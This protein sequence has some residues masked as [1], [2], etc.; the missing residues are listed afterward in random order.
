MP[1]ETNLPDP[2]DGFLE[3]KEVVRAMLA[4]TPNLAMLVNQEGMI[5]GANHAMADSLSVS[6]DRLTG[7]RLH[8][9]FLPEV[10]ERR[11]PFLI[12]ALACGETVEFEDVR[13]HRVFVTRIVPIRD[14]TGACSHAFV[15]SEDVTHERDTE[16]TLR[17]N[18]NR[19]QTLIESLPQGVFYKDRSLTYVMCN[20]RYARDLCRSREEI[21]GTSDFDLF[22]P[23]VA[24]S[25]RV[26]DRHVLET[27]EEVALEGRSES[28]S[29]HPGRYQQFVKSPVRDPSGQVVGILGIYW[30]ITERKRAE[31]QQERFNEMQK[32]MVTLVA[33][34]LKTPLTAIAG[35][36]DLLAGGTRDRRHGEE[37]RDG[38]RRNIR[39]LE[40][41]IDKFLDLERIESRSLSLER[42]RFSLSDLLGSL[43]RQHTFAWKRKGLLVEARI[44]ETL[45]LYGDRDLLARA[46]SNILSNAIKFTDRGSIR[47]TARQVD[48]EIL[49]E[50]VDTGCGIAPSSLPHVFERF[51]HAETE[52]EADSDT[53]LRRGLGLTLARTII[54]E[55][56]GRI[57][58]R[59]QI[60]KGTTVTV[61]LPRGL[62]DPPHG[63]S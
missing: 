1:P 13:D 33:H 14:R 23:G 63:V 26:S 15:F 31:E 61:A 55:H 60:D 30:D 53:S 48:A 7:T 56:G 37:I 22:P 46:L 42:S 11:N 44:D 10:F 2:L 5:L 29:Q 50:T 19:Y 57:G 45:E 54:E 62:A 20:E 8:T 32:R 4:G 21:I 28:H 51:F 12:Q 34:E 58:I 52:S 3:T 9:L 16:S 43:V 49:I 6:L 47:V 38:I 18:E 17:E 41:L 35:Y 36:A 24:E 59:S 27:G 25:Y 39:R 40:Q